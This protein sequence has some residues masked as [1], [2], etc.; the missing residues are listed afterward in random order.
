MENFQKQ[1]KRIST[2]TLLSL[3]ALI[4]EIIS[5]HRHNLLDYR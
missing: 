1:I 3:S 5:E 2:K 4:F